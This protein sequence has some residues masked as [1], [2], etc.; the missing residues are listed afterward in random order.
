[1][2]YYDKVKLTEAII[3][4]FMVAGMVGVGLSVAVAGDEAKYETGVVRTK[5]DSALYVSPVNDTLVERKIL[6][7]DNATKSYK[8]YEAIQIGDTLKFEN[9][10]HDPIINAGYSYSDMKVNNKDIKKAI[11]QFNRTKQLQQ[12]QR[13]SRQK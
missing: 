2:V 7:T 4:F 1:M 6:F 8:A 5:K 9:P 13:E 3:A 11:E 12:I 10:T